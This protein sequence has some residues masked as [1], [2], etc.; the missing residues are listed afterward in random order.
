MAATWIALDV[1][2]ELQH[3]LLPIHSMA[4]PPLFSLRNAVSNQTGRQDILGLG[5]VPHTSPCKFKFKTK[6]MRPRYPAHTSNNP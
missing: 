1:E 2:G 3:Y 4:E 5:G 6:M